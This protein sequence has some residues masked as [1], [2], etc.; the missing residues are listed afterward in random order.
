LA[1]ILNTFIL[2]NYANRMLY[3]TVTQIKAGKT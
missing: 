1:L 2:G 3:S